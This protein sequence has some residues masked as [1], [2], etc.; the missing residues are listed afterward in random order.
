MK[1]C[2]NCYYNRGIYDGMVDCDILNDFLKDK[3][4]IRNKNNQ[5]F[6][7]FITNELKL[8]G[9]IFFDEKLKKILIKDG[10]CKN[11]AQKR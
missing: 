7:E 8:N 5:K 11:F 4:D 3:I 2:E 1:K 10:S 6:Y 9:D